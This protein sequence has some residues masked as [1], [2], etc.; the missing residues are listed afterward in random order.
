M[1]TRDG[2]RET[3][4]LDIQIGICA[5]SI[6]FHDSILRDE[7]GKKI[8]RQIFEISEFVSVYT[9]ILSW[10]RQQRRQRRYQYSKYG[11]V[12]YN[13]HAYPNA[14]SVRLGTQVWPPKPSKVFA[15]PS[16]STS[17]SLFLLR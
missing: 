14:T 4:I 12:N 9:F 1:G 3:N 7:N 10:N 6:L 16:F 13:F 17:H 5:N 2:N 11:G 8:G 15:T